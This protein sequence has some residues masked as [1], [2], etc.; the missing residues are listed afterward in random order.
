MSKPTICFIGLGI[1][2]KPMAANLLKSGYP[3]IVFNRT[4]EKMAS[5][6]AQ[7]ARAA[8]SIADC[9]GRADVTMTMLP[10]SPD[11][12]EVIAGSTG[13]AGAAKA[14][15]IVV[16]MSSISPLV[17]RK[18][19]DTLN[20]KS[21]DF[22]DAPVSGGEP[23]AIAGTLAI[24]AGGGEA[25]FERVKPILQVMGKSVIRVGDVG[26]GNYAKLANQIIV[27][28]TIAAVGE[29]FVLAQKAGLDPDVLYRA[30][31]DGLA[32]S[33]VLDAKAPRVMNRVFEPGFKIRLHQK[34]LKN[35]L[36]T[37]RE[38]GVP[39]PLTAGVQQMLTAL[40]ADGKGELDHGAIVQF[41]EKISGV[42][43]QKIDGISEKIS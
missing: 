31:K 24:M 17:S 30:I 20:K 29:A 4:R 43:I 35:V 3:L 2:G 13:V 23:G 25:A 14:H 28:L 19:A 32:G 6:V 26:A 39:L 33:R 7:G 8:D 16:D 9:A 21:I 5:L 12:Q 10:D 18:M 37:A 36:E 34:D 42:K 1:M 41:A 27:A 11:V 40:M 22:L 38:I 15:S